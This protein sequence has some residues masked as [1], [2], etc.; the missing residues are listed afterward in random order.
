MHLMGHFKLFCR[1]QRI[2]IIRSSWYLVY[3]SVFVMYCGNMFT[4]VVYFAF[5]TPLQFYSFTVF[6]K[7]KRWF[8]SG[9]TGWKP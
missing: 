6:E 2:F 4:C 8:Y 9:F 1:F 3:D 5:I 7:Q